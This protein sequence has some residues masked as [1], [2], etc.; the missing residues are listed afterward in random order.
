MK[1]L[2]LTRLAP[3]VLVLASSATSALADVERW[4]VT[5]VRA[6]FPSQNITGW[7]DYDTATAGIPNWS[8]TTN[9]NAAVNTNF[10]PPATGTLQ[11]CI[12]GCSAS[13]SGSLTVGTPGGELS[14]TNDAN[15]AA[16]F[17]VGLGLPGGFSLDGSGPSTI[18]L[19]AGFPSSE[20]VALN[21]SGGFTD[22]PVA[23]SL[24]Y[25]GAVLNDFQGGSPS[26]P[27]SITGAVGEINASLGGAFGDADF[28]KITTA[29]AN[30]ATAT[31]SGA[32]PGSVFVFRLLR[33]N[34]TAAAGIVLDSA[35]DFSG[36][37]TIPAGSWYIGVVDNNL[38]D[39][40]LT[41][42]FS[43]PVT[44]GLPVPEPASWFLL[45]TGFLGLAL[46]TRRRLH[47]RAP[48]SLKCFAIFAQLAA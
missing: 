30:S 12:S 29:S 2:L 4:D 23:G 35:D 47:Q 40:G 31:I 11:P 3:A 41:I 8:I 5:A 22:F 16:E 27:V 36:T 17:F 28:Y 10:F 42:D 6:A 38:A 43:T 21:T 14:F 1:R 26:N 48:L 15:P 46:F 32:A 44:A 9:G 7:F 25:G 19:V 20:A 37:L 24:T 45:S 33:T 34:S 18:D 39:P 13:L